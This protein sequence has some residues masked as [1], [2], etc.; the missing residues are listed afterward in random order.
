MKGIQFQDDPGTKLQAD[1]YWSTF[2]VMPVSRSIGR[3]RSRSVGGKVVERKT[4]LQSYFANVGVPKVGVCVCVCV[5][6]M[7]EMKE[8]SISSLSVLWRRVKAGEIESKCVSVG[9][10]QG[11]NQS[12]NKIVLTVYRWGVGLP[13]YACVWKGCVSIHTCLREQTNKS[14]D[15]SREVN[16]SVSRRRMQSVISFSAEIK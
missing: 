12:I 5:Y 9:T 3:N 7:L 4:T 2:D 14:I 8:N 1:R 6:D 15:Q 13:T 16:N 11:P 10:H